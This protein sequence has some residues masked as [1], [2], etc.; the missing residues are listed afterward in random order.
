MPSR[1]LRTAVILAAALPVLHAGPAEAQAPNAKLACL[2]ASDSAQQLRAAGKLVAARDALKSCVL[3]EC[4]SVVREACSQWMGEVT[5]SLPTIVVGARDADGKDIVDLKVS[6]DGAVVT[7]HLG[8]RALP[9]DPGRHK[10]HYETPSGA[11]VDEEILVREGEK[12]RELTV[13][14]PGAPKAPG[15]P[16]SGGTEAPRGGGGREASTGNTVIGTILAAVGAAGL[17]TALYLDLSTTSDV[18]ALKAGCGKTGT[19]SA[20]QV[21][22]DELG[23]D[24]AG[25]SLGVGI[26]AVGIATYV[27]I[28]HPFGTPTPATQSHAF[29]IV[30]VPHGS[31][32]A[33]TF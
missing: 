2:K 20:S 24:L 16:G 5:A 25:V 6:I 12:N 32:F 13:V 29:R 30:P 33:F 18:N 28:A 31:G 9:I 8:G 3:D 10:M 19:C 23:Y 26:V 17:G 22:S 11:I 15:A 4:P 21:S 1:R 27:F 14:F 7:E